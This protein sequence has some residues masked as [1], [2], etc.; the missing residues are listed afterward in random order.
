MS[1]DCCFL[2]LF[3]LCWPNL[4][5]FLYWLL[6]PTPGLSQCP[7]LRHIH[8]GAGAV[9]VPSIRQQGGD[10]GVGSE[11][12][13]QSTFRSLPWP[14]SLGRWPLPGAAIFDDW[15]WEAKE[16]SGLAWA[17]PPASWTPG[18]GCICISFYSF[19]PSVLH[20]YSSTWFLS[21]PNAFMQT[22]V[23]RAILERLWPAWGIIWVIP[24]AI[25]SQLYYYYYYKLWHFWWW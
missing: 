3:P 20:T 19:C 5:V 18:W 4:E 21:P 16:G 23:L 13:A 25:L 17:R 1:L 2:C 10:V 15:S 8:I 9:V 12:P 11:V 7:S 22:S 24:Y 6:P 14:R